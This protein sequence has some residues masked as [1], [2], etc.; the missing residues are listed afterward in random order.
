[1]RR[2]TFLSQVCATAAAG[3]VPLVPAEAAG[4]NPTGYIRTNWSRDPYALGAYSYFAKGS[5]RRHT[6]A[7]AAP[8][9]DRLFFAGEATHPEYNSTVHAALEAGQIAAD[10][11]ERT[12]HK[13]VAVIGAG[14]SGLAAA[15]Q[16]ADS[17]YQVTVYEAKRRI[18][19]R[20]WTDNRLGLPLDLGASWLHGTRGNPLT[21]MVKA[22]RMPTRATDDSYVIRGGD[23]RQMRDQDTPDWIDV[24]TEIQHDIGA[25]PN[26]LNRSAYQRDDDYGGEEWIFP[27][28]YITILRTLNRGLD[29]RLGTDIRRV[30][31]TA[32]GVA[33][34][35][36]RG[37]KS[38]HDAVVV[39]V[40]LGVLKRGHITFAPALPQPKRQAIARL[41][42]GIL[43]KVYLRYGSVFWDR[44]ATW[45]ITPET[46][47]PRGQFN[48]WL[49]LYPYIG[50]PVLVAFNGAQPALDLARLS[51][52]KLVQLAHKTLVRAYPG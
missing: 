10:A 21:R 44:D 52:K 34:Q 39:T 6:R 26:Q 37:S 22:A 30:D 9:G 47:L 36:T 38:A 14:I 33:L 29:I 35:D 49:N 5:D 23:G 27:N 2:R 31:V 12:R 24:V 48:Q 25:N 15:R 50:H 18:G 46:G 41:G 43:D 7:L 16:L 40:P 3:F 11:V 32:S 20:I 28:G 19:G 42:M 51:D 4:N 1:M 45:I 8:V 17:G 13:R